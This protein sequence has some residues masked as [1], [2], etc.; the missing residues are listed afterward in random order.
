MNCLQKQNITMFP[1][2]YCRKDELKLKST[3]IT[4]PFMFI[5][6]CKCRMPEAPGLTM[7]QCSKCKT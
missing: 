6:Y 7:I 3:T 4:V 2:K 5:V 1:M